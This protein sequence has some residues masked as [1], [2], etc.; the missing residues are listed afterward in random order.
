MSARAPHV[1]KDVHEEGLASHSYFDREQGTAAIKLLPNEY[2]VTGEDILLTTVLGSCV[3]ACVRDPVAGVGGMNHFMLPVAGED[4]RGDALAS[5]RYGAYAMEVLLNT[6]YASGAQRERLEAKVFGG[7]MVLADMTVARIGEANADFVLDYLQA[8]HI[9]LLA[10][11][12]KDKYPRRVHYFPASGR[13]LVKR[14]KRQDSVL[15]QHDKALAKT[16][17]HAP[18]TAAVIARD[19]TSS[20]RSE[21]LG[22]N[23]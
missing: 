13:A 14:F 20:R 19:T 4:V 10:Q 18:S 23:A 21:M 9:R 5:M 6:L 22:G 1:M 3:A 17:A 2:F 7:A 8:Q 16:L 12:L 11:D 15:A